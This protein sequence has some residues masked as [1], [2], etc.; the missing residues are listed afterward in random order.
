[1]LPFIESVT[2]RW[3]HVYTIALYNVSLTYISRKR[4]VISK[5]NAVAFLLLCQIHFH[6]ESWCLIEMF[7]IDF[8]SCNSAQLLKMIYFSTGGKRHRLFCTHIRSWPPTETS[9]W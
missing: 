2:D 7:L 8:F 1:M 3:L 4:L 6:Y 9:L 5:M